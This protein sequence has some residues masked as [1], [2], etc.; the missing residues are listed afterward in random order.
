MIRLIVIFSFIVSG[1][2]YSSLVFSAS[3]KMLLSCKTLSHVYSQYNIPLPIN[4]RDGNEENSLS[5]SQRFE[6]FKEYFSSKHHDQYECDDALYD[7]YKN[8]ENSLLNDALEQSK[9][10][11]EDETSSMLLMPKTCLAYRK[12]YIQHIISKLQE[13]EKYL[14]DMVALVDISIQ[15]MLYN[16][17]QA[18]L[19]KYC[20]YARQVWTRDP[21]ITKKEYESSKKL[22]PLT[23]HCE[24]EFSEF[25]DIVFDD[26]GPTEKNKIIDGWGVLVLQGKQIFDYAASGL[27]ERRA[28]LSLLYKGNENNMDDACN[29]NHLTQ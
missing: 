21:D 28:W 22:Y 10:K 20:N 4:T 15:K 9:G 24:K 7:L 14:P 16:Q 19:N 12:V 8:I 27:M 13:P 29:Y 11:M 2:G 17:P 3:Q 6:I 23:P 5:A 26:F 25:E 18:I 1:M